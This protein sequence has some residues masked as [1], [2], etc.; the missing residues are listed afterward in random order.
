M[1]KSHITHPNE[2]L[3]PQ[4]GQSTDAPS[5]SKNKSRQ[6]LKKVLKVINYILEGVV[7]PLTD[8]TRGGGLKKTLLQMR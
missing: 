4:F 7:R 6:Q 8:F 2:A 5:F 1:Q 3:D